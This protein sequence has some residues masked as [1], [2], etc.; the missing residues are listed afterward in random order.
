MKHW[1]EFDNAMLYESPKITI[2][3]SSIRSFQKAFDCEEDILLK[4]NNGEVYRVKMTYE[5]LKD[6]LF[7]MADS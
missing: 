1:Y 2:D 4:T 7:A 5:K 3:L 6:I